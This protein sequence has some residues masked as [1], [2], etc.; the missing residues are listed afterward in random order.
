MKYTGKLDF[1]MNG[2]Y[3]IYTGDKYIP[4]SSML[5]SM[6]GDEV[7]VRILNKNDK[8]LFKDQGIILRE[9]LIT[10]GSNQSNL[11]TYRVNGQDLDSVLWDN[12]GKKITF[13]LHNGNKNKATEE[14][15]IR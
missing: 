2:E 10:N 7:K 11:Y 15:D 13:I 8:E 6:L 1:N 9:K 14:E 12:V 5:N 4:I 3:A